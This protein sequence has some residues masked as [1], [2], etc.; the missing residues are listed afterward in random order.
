MGQ[1]QPMSETHEG[2]RALALEIAID[3]R[4][5]THCGFHDCVYSG[6]KAIE[7][8]YEL[9]QAQ[10]R[11]FHNVFRSQSELYDTIKEVVDDHS[12]AECPHCAAIRRGK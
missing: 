2:K 1:L 6:G 4:V 5:L 8:A 11:E 9:A 12:A 10:Y 3:A 7:A